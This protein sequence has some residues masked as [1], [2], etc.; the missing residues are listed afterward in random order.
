[1]GSEGRKGEALEE[2]QNQ[3]DKWC[4]PLAWELILY[5]ENTYVKGYVWMAM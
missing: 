1:M 4:C 3:C 5:P 2:I